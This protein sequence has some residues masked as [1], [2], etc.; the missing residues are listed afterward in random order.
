M[1]SGTLNARYASIAALC[2]ALG[3][4]S[5]YAI[6]LIHGEIAEHPGKFFGALLGAALVSYV[7]EWLRDLIRVGEIEVDTHPII[8]SLGTFVVVLMFELFISGFHAGFEMGPTKV[9]QAASGLL[10]PETAAVQGVPWT[11][12][13]VAGVWVLAG[14]LLAAWL[15]AKVGE[16]T[17]TADAPHILRSSGWGV[18]GGMVIAPLVI[19][20]YIFLG[21]CLVTL[22]Y[23]ARATPE[24]ASQYPSLSGLYNSIFHTNSPGF[25]AAFDLPMTGLRIAATHGLWVF[26]LS[27][28]GLLIVAVAAV[29]FLSERSQKNKETNPIAKLI[30]FGTL[31]AVFSPILRSVWAVLTLLMTQKALHAFFGAMGLG[32]IIWGVPG[33]LLGALV[34]L[35]RRAGRKPESWALIGYGSAALLIAASLLTWHVWPLLP[36]AIALGSGLLFRRGMPV[37]E[38][39][40]FAAL[41]VAIGVSG[42]MSVTQKI[43]FAGVLGRLHTL[44]EIQPALPTPEVAQASPLL[45]KP[46]ERM[47]FSPQVSLQES[48]D[49]IDS[50]ARQGGEQ[51]HPQ[52]LAAPRH[53]TLQPHTEFNK[54]T[55]EASPLASTPA[56]D[57]FKISPQEMQALLEA[58]RKERI[59]KQETAA[60]LA[61]PTPA[62]EQKELAAP[63]AEESVAKTEPVRERVAS[64]EKKEGSHTEKA[65]AEGEELES[66]EDAAKVLEISIAG[67]VGFWTTVGLLACWSMFERENEEAEH[68]HSPSGEPTEVA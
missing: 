45:R 15:S 19:G 61:P 37:K 26:W 29:G 39:W 40:P 24:M 68:M 58:L 65:G 23:F 30:I 57:K 2:G 27:Y 49:L 35:L 31:F 66:P 54:K 62:A 11:V 14:A 32:A 25:I 55:E 67:S 17:A 42:A 28:G 10:G 7:I 46:V 36:A 50:M 18:I 1:A 8:R 20:A 63:P 13:L 56:Q 21:R 9:L 33:L 6:F 41:C 4:M 3:V 59:Q 34:P 51:P 53:L 38:F 52:L 5:G 44:D 16:E 12:V 43:T 60:L 22:E 64:E 48:Q 47:M